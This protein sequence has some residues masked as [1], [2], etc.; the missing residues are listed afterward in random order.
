MGYFV[1]FVVIMAAWFTHVITCLAA[2]A[3]GFLIAGAL[4]VPIAVVHGVMIWFGMG[5]IL[6]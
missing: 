1:F 5:P 4:L 2:S 3:W 6:N